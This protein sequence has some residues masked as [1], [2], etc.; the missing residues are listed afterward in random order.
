MFAPSGRSGGRCRAL[1]YVAAL[2]VA[3]LSGV[4]ARAEA[5]LPPER[6]APL[7][8]GVLAFR[9]VPLTQAA[10]QPLAA[11][12]GAAV[13]DCTF[14]V[15]ALGFR[16][17]EA[18]VA[19]HRLDLV[20]TN[21]GH[22]VAIDGR[23]P[24]SGVLATV[25][26]EGT[27]APVARMAGVIV[28]RSDRKD[29]AGLRDLARARIAAVGKDSLGGYQAQE[30]ELVRAGV[31][32]PAAERLL[33]TGM[34]HDRVVAAVLSGEADAGF[35]R[36]GV[37]E[38]LA[39]EGTLDLRELAVIHRQDTPGFPYAA[40][41]SLY[42]GWPVVALAHLDERLARR[43]AAA[44]LQ[45]DPGD[46]RHA[47]GGYHAFTIPA[48]Y[49]QVEVLLRELRLP[50]FQGTPA[51]DLRD[52]LRRYRRPLAGIAAGAAIIALLT[53]SLARSLRRLRLAHATRERTMAELQETL[54]QVRTLS[55]LL[56]I[57][58]HCKKIRN[59]AGYWNKIEQYIAER[60]DATF[61]HGLCPECAEVH[62]PAPE[63][64]P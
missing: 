17:L 52:V 2:L 49:S 25:V 8:V 46:G 9:P 41:T 10:W 23:E 55:G 26:E 19:A 22:Y 31:A 11:A 43:I 30:Y 56:P 21:P 12:L 20:I 45:L 44:L 28:A 24:M 54:Q 34:P 61:T 50:P 35:L 47:V 60:T 32:P 62:Y 39:A 64:M 3:A 33:S 57:C 42:P 15:E 38:Q 13:P 58:M 7:V 59:D 37:I 36:A 5:A 51:F 4:Q 1:A 6:P 27:D 18:A 29:L 14:A 16:E 40:S 53:I 63:G 48:N